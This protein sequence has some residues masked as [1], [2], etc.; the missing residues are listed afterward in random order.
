MAANSADEPLRVAQAVQRDERD[1]NRCVFGIVPVLRVVCIFLVLPQLESARAAE[2]D[3]ADAQIPADCGDP[4]PSAIEYRDAGDEHARPGD[5]LAEVIRAAHYAEE[6]DIAEA[7]WV[8]LLEPV[9]R[10]IRGGFEYDANAHD[11]RAHNGDGVGSRMVLQTERNW[12]GLACVEQC[13]THPGEK[14][15]RQFDLRAV[16]DRLL[17]HLMI[18]GAAVF[19]CKQIAA[20]P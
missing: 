17:H 6:P 14:F 11:R 16:V 13:A 9:L 4:L 19:A 5:D 7:V 8:L 15:E 20:E 12:R 18:G 3:P 2:H 1:E 10:E